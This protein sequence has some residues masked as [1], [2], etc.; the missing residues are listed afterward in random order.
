MLNS[1]DFFDFCSWLVEDFSAT[2]RANESFFKICALDF[3]FTL[4]TFVC[5]HFIFIVYLFKVLII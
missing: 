4:E 3:S 5:W 1:L 2:M